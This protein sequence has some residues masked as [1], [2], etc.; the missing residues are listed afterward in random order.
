[1]ACI[2]HSESFD[3]VMSIRYLVN[4]FRYSMSHFLDENEVSLQWKFRLKM[5]LFNATKTLKN[6][7]KM[8]TVCLTIS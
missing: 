5:F 8:L 3:F 6:A 4:Y 1:M 7:Y 2:C